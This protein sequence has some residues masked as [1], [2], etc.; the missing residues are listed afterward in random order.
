MTNQDSSETEWFV[1]QEGKQTGPFSNNEVWGLVHSGKIGPDN[2]VWKEGMDNWVAVAAIPELAAVLKSQDE[3][4]ESLQSSSKETPQ[5]PIENALFVSASIA[6][7]LLAIL[8]IGALLRL[9]ITYTMYSMLA[10]SLVE[11]YT[12]GVLGF[13]LTRRF[14]LNVV[15]RLIYIM[16][17]L[18]G[19]MAIANITLFI[20]RSGS[21][22]Y[23]RPLYFFSSLFQ[24]GLY[25]AMLVISIQRKTRVYG[26]FRS[27]CW[28]SIVSLMLSPF[29][30]RLYM[31]VRLLYVTREILLGIL[32][33]KAVRDTGSPTPKQ[34]S[35]PVIHSPVDKR[36][37]L[38]GIIVY[39]IIVSIF[40]GQAVLSIKIQEK[41]LFDLFLILNGPFLII[42]SIIGFPDAPVLWFFIS[43]IYFSILF[44]PLGVIMITRK[45]K[46]LM[47]VL[48]VIALLLHFGCGI[49]IKFVE[50]TGML[51]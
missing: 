9:P 29:Y 26:L 46:I 3:Q 4:P 33:I 38:W 8:S 39:V 6:C 31:P 44:L 10:M 40:V 22:N 37:R 7:C 14:R 21:G 49:L 45:L 32:F 23:L 30:F 48:Q 1:E 13:L 42:G 28:I 20:I 2:L 18:V 5:S 50:E 17:G 11:I 19:A 27:Y 47:I 16:M 34:T 36:K 35:I 15:S 24:I 12:L 25:V 41:G 51:M 43:V